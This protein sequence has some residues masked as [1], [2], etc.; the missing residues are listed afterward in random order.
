MD[1]KWR[2]VGTDFWL[3]TAKFGAERSVGMSPWAVGLCDIVRFA[4]GLES[5]RKAVLAD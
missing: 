1:S 4:A 5:W 3:S 2:G